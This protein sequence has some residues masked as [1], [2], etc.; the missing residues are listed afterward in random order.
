MLEDLNQAVSTVQ[1]IPRVRFESGL[2]PDA[3]RWLEKKHANGAVHE[4]GTLAAFLAIQKHKQVK[5]VFDL[6]ALF[7]Y[8]TLFAL[9]VFDDAAV[10]AFEMHPVVMP[11]LRKNVEPWAK[12]VHAVMSDEV[13]PPTQFWVS[14]FNIYEEPEGGWS[15]LKN[16]P[17][18]MKPR[19]ENNRGAGFAKVPFST[20][21]AYC[22]EHPAP[23]LLKIDVEAYQAK[24]VLGGLKTIAAHRPAI[25][26]ELHDGE[27]IARM[28]TTNKATVQP[29]FELGYS[30]Y[31]CSNFRDK[32]ARFEPVTEM[33]AEHERLGIM[34]LVP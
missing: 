7:G 20:I 18:A 21:D 6:G 17:G 22:A 24:A 31:W 3:V 8:F 12:V 34:V 32:D 4:P 27:K 10:T 33:G 5:Q 28:G 13:K 15:N 9:Q 1:R 23:D 14:G 11:E 29:L 16:Q 19:G 30:A 25:V 2:A 26:I